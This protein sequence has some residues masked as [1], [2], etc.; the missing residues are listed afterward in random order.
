VHTAHLDPSALG[1]DSDPERREEARRAF[2]EQVRA[3]A[4]RTAERLLRAE[5]VPAP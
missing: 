3:E 1:P 5:P 2:D 4:E